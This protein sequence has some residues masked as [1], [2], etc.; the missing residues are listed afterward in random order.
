VGGKAKAKESRK[1]ENN[2]GNKFTV[3]AVDSCLIIGYFRVEIN[4]IISRYAK[5]S[6]SPKEI[7]VRFGR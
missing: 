7:N 6:F 4:K 2:T 1:E 3:P 5:K